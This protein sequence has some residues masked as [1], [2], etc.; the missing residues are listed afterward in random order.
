MRSNKLR[1]V[2]SVSF[3][4][5]VLGFCASLEAAAK[6]CTGKYER[7]NGEAFFTV[8]C[9]NETDTCF[10]HSEGIVC[11]SNQKDINP[12]EWTFVPG[13]CE[14]HWCTPNS[15]PVCPTV[16]DPV[17]CDNEVVYS[18]QCF[19]NAECAVGCTPY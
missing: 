8:A 13:S 19:A 1:I 9:A 7:P 4:V 10:C 17:I 6:Y 12:E 3:L 15:N 11:G 14:E 5:L 18:N 2:I 16:F